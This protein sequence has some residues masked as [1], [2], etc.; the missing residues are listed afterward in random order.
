MK[1][2]S[3]QNLKVALDLSTWMIK[4]QRFADYPKGPETKRMMQRHELHLNYVSG[5]QGHSTWRNMKVWVSMRII[6]AR[7]NRL[8]G[9][10]Q[11]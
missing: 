3:L 2:S 7:Y 6:T 10:H 9:N 11:K 4:K 5:T 8:I 1:A